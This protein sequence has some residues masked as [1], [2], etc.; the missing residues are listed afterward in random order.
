MPLLALVLGTTPSPPASPSLSS[1]FD[2]ALCGASYGVPGVYM[3]HGMADCNGVCA[4]AGAQCI[5]PDEQ[6]ITADC[7]QQAAAHFGF[8]C[9]MDGTAPMPNEYP[10]YQ[11]SAQARPPQASSSTPDLRPPQT[12]VTPDLLGRLGPHR[13]H[14]DTTATK[15]FW[16]PWSW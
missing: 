4:A 3:L 2:P 12:C 7:V 6:S 9:L 8:T 13:R 10:G 11:T 16:R 5:V 14:A 1:G 15:G